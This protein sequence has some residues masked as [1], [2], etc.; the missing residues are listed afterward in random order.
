[1]THTHPFLLHHCH[2]L[3]YGRIMTSIIL[4]GG[5]RGGSSSEFPSIFSSISA[6]PSSFCPISEF[7]KLK[8]QNVFFWQTLVC[9]LLDS[10]DT[11][12]IH[13]SLLNSAY[14]DEKIAKYRIESVKKCNTWEKQSIII[15]FSTG[16]VPISAAGCRWFW[17]DFRFSDHFF[18]QFL[19][20][21]I[22]CPRKITL[23]KID[24]GK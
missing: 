8:Q 3:I 16:S 20:A 2:L 4:R 9:L 15:E 14:F 6:F 24:T 11:Q 19:L 1:M 18:S 23:Y 13:L 10:I 5:R 21:E 22:P 7:P 12:L 17:N